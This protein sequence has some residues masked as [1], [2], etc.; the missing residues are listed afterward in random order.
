[1]SILHF[2]APSAPPQPKQ[3][4][5]RR[6]QEAW[7]HCPPGSIE[8]LSLAAMGIVETARDIKIQA[9]SAAPNAAAIDGLRRALAAYEREYDNG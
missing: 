3:S 2:P 4:P 7:A 1:M 8:R 6:A 9:A 5:L